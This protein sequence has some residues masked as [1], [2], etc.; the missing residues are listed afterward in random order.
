[1][2]TYIFTEQ[3]QYVPQIKNNKMNNI[4]VNK[5]LNKYQLIFVF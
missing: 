3:Q 5:A 1:M 2:E 4:K